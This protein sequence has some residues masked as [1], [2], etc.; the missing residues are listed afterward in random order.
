ML[1]YCRAKIA[2]AK[3]NCAD[4]LI[5]AKTV[6]SNYFLFEKKLT[7]KYQNDGLL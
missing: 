5:G 4:L 2:R 1:D 6:G 3:N 7:P